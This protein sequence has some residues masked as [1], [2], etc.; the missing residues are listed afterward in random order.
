[1]TDTPR[2]FGLVRLELIWLIRLPAAVPDLE[3]RLRWHRLDYGP[4]A[5]AVSR[6]GAASALGVGAGD[7]V[8]AVLHAGRQAAERLAAAPVRSEG[9]CYFP[10]PIRRPA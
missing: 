6:S 8:A 5:D 2:S 10:E 9:S 1:M 7:L 3:A 4:V